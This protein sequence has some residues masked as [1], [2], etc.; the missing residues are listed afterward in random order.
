MSGVEQSNLK[1]RAVEVRPVDA[2]AEEHDDALSDPVPVLRRLIDVDIRARGHDHTDFTLVIVDAVAVWDRNRLDGCRSVALSAPVRLPDD[3]LHAHER[4]GEEGSREVLRPVID[5]T[6]LIK[7]A[8][9]R[10]EL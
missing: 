9:E 6:E 5:E 3:D 7:G 4:P 10:P 2:Q 8:G 1:S